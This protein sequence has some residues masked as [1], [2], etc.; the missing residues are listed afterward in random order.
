MSVMFMGASTGCNTV[1][2]S[3]PPT[4][5][6]PHPWMNSLFQDGATISCLLSE[7]V[8]VNQARRSVV[9]ERIPDALLE[10]DEGVM[11]DASYF[12]LTPLDDALMTDQEIRELPKVWVI[13]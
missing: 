3:T 13:G 2:G 9:P 4:N 10:R 7:S 1:Y 8:A 12:T 5:P 11:T 6:H